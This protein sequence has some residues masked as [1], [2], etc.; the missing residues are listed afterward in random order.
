[1]DDLLTVFLKALFP[2][3]SECSQRT[4]DPGTMTCRTKSLLR[5][6]LWCFSHNCLTGKTIC[7][8]PGNTGSTSWGG[9]FSRTQE[10]W[11]LTAFIAFQSVKSSDSFTKDFQFHFRFCAKIQRPLTQ[12]FFRLYRSGL[13]FNR[14]FP[15]PWNTARYSSVRK[16]VPV[17]VIA[18][19]FC[20][21]SSLLSFITIKPESW[22]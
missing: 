15:W 1:M 5:L 18:S 21:H 9:I 14:T 8:L 2:L 11:Y 22:S 3:D 4:S 10:C 20:K 12:P 6:Y 13:C 7:S 16:Q 17:Q 19:Y